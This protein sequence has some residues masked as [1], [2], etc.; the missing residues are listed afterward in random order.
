MVI[1]YSLCGFCSLCDL[2]LFSLFFGL[3]PFYSF[4]WG[5]KLDRVLQLNLPKTYRN[6]STSGC[7]YFRHFHA[8]QCHDTNYSWSFSDSLQFQI[9]LWK[10]YYFKITF[11]PLFVQLTFLLKQWHLHMYFVFH[12]ICRSF[13]QLCKVILIDLPAFLHC[14]YQLHSILKFKNTQLISMLFSFIIR[15]T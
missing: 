13:C 12:P 8:S 2:A 6:R 15:L 4:K 3:F 14:F 1:V 9:P 7:E 11:P 10:K 5:A